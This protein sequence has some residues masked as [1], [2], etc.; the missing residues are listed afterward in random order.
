MVAQPILVDRRGGGRDTDLVG[1]GHHPRGLLVLEARGCDQ[2]AARAERAQH[3]ASRLDQGE[4][5]PAAVKAREDPGHRRPALD[6]LRCGV[7]AHVGPAPDD[8]PRQPGPR[9]LAD[10]G[11]AAPFHPGERQALAHLLARAAAVGSAVDPQR[12]ALALA[13]GQKR[14]RERADDRGDAHGGAPSR[15]GPTRR[16]RPA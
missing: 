16:G 5:A 9:L 6:P 3:A 8:D 15:G 2:A 14:L 1:A 13:A 12:Q 10:H 7:A 11:G 4:P